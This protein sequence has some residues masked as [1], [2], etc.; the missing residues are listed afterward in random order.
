MAPPSLSP[1]APKQGMLR[2]RVDVDVE[3]AFS[4]LAKKRGIKTSDL[5]RSLVL[6]ELGQVGPGQT[7][8]EPDAANADIKVLQVRLPGFLQDAI[9]ARANM[10]GMPP[11]RWASALLQSNLSRLPVFNEDEIS[12]LRENNR[13]LFKIGTNVNQIAKSLNESFHDTER[14]RL[15][16]LADLSNSIVRTRNVIRAIVRN[17]RRGWEADEP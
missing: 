13:Q 6:A 1:T 11:G 14:V 4:A 17:T 7:Q 16:V 5:L 8:V 15:D 10:R 9:R 12:A 3:Q 2:A